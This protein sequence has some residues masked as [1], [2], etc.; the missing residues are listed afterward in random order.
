MRIR[1]RLLLILVAI[2]ALTVA[3]DEPVA[4]RPR[5]PGYWAEASGRLNWREPETLFEKVR[6]LL[7]VPRYVKVT[8]GVEP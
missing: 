6:R 2:A 7:R 1:T 3:G 5:P 8:G 4:I